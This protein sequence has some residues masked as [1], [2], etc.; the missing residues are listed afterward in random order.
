MTNV[1]HPA[2]KVGD[3]IKKLSK[4]ILLSTVIVG[5]AAGLSACKEDVLI[6][7][8]EFSGTENGAFTDNG[9]YYF[10]ADLLSP[11]K[12]SSIAELQWD[13]EKYS[14]TP[15]VLGLFDGQYCGFNGLTSHGNILYATCTFA[16]ETPTGALGESGDS[17]LVR[18]DTNKQPD[19][20]GYVQH[21]PL[22][23]EGS[24]GNGMAADANGDL[25]I[26][27]SLAWVRSYMLGDIRPA[28]V[29]VSVNDDDGFSI[30]QDAWHY[31]ALNDMFPN[32]IRVTR[33]HVY[34]V[35]GTAFKRFRLLKD[36]SAGPDLTL[37][38]ADPCHLM[39]DFDIKRNGF[40]AMTE[41]PVFDPSI[42]ALLWP[43][44]DCSNVAMAGRLVG[45][46]GKAFGGKLDEFTYPDG[47]LPSSAMFPTH[48]AVKNYPLM[49]S[50][51]AVSTAF[52][53]GGVQQVSLSDED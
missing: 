30:S 33:K 47:T 9:V 50:F 31:P 21:V 35:A 41:I 32:G 24:V 17:V 27:D 16:P 10:A 37:Y 11:T 45:I 25:Y 38:N 39:D 52:F 42:N 8:Q 13:G 15:I 53:T 34:F 49:T 20:A 44:A 28:I 48:A 14:A 18:V 43:G 36:G 51:S 1:N 7:P 6:T 19:E 26:T 29:K 3:K 5:T 40:V 22:F 23:T 12:P 46:N 2:K 4:K